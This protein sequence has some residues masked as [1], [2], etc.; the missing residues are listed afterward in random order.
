MKISFNGFRGFEETDN[1]IH[2][3]NITIL[4]GKNS[5][6][7][8]TFIKLLNAFISSIKKTDSFM[9]LFDIEID[10][11]NNTLGGAQ[12]LINK[13]VPQPYICI[14]FI[15]VFFL[16]PHYLH[17]YFE[18]SDSKL[19]VSKYVLYIK[20]KNNKLL[21]ILEFDK[22]FHR[23]NCNLLYD[24]YKRYALVFNVCEE[25]DIANYK[26]KSV[27]YWKGYNLRY[28][29]GYNE[30]INNYLHL[31]QS[32]QI[33]NDIISTLPY[34]NEE[35]E[36]PFS[37]WCTD[38]QGICFLFNL[39]FPNLKIPKTL[40]TVIIEEL[41]NSENIS[42]KDSA[43]KL[44]L[45]DELINSQNEILTD[46]IVSNYIIIDRYDKFYS[47]HGFIKN[48][49]IFQFLNENDPNEPAKNSFKVFDNINTVRDFLDDYCIINENAQKLIRNS[50]TIYFQSILHLFKK[51][52]HI[53]YYR[54]NEILPL[55]GYNL[56]EKDNLFSLTIKEL[57]SKNKNSIND[58]NLNNIN[59]LVQL[60]KIAD[61]LQ[62]DIKD[63]YGFIYLIKGKS[64][65]SL[66]DEGSGT[67]NLIALLLFLETV[68]ENG[69]VLIEEPE[70]KLHP[71]LQSNIADILAYYSLKK[72]LKI[73]VETHSEY[74]IRKLQYLVAKKEINNDK[75]SLY[76]FS[77]SRNKI[78]ADEITIN[79]NGILSKEFGSGFFDE[80]NNLAIDL[81]KLTLTQQN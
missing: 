55:R 46:L 67:A 11:S 16:E 5:S 14:E 40:I 76:Y 50:S 37:L 56:F 1:Q 64:K 51:L 63:S 73:L 21:S 3:N 57:I 72:E 68:K 61:A 48:H 12:N 32:V 36:E 19:S 74:L 70:A 69:V 41:L 44:L 4:T 9:D 33:N 27:P 7:K 28:Q 34:K 2:I 35:S 26:K 13:D 42:E 25:Q 30:I 81:F 18:V 71:N 62:I 65:Y 10:I 23:S 15:P 47:N 79:K 6:G 53:K 66:I 80:A 58:I 24:L 17:I 8:S 22:S 20:G 60:L 39:N 31:H 29:K 78:K 77:T 38:K 45:Y 59:N 75:I 52:K 43:F 54:H 49:K